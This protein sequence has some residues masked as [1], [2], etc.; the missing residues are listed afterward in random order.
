MARIGSS[1]FAFP[2]FSGATRTLVFVEPGRLLCT[3]SARALLLGRNVALRFFGLLAFDPGLPARLS[4]A[5]A[6]LQ[7]RPR[8]LIGTLFELL[9]LW[10][11]AGFLEQMHSSAWVNGPL[12]RLSAGNRRRRYLPS[13]P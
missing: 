13:T 5:A 3:A 11:L 4:L 8:G 2:D 6:Y 1:P 12:C 10:F 7:L 9:S